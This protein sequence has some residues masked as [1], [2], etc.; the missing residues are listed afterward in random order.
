LFLV[1]RSASVFFLVLFC[2]FLKWNK[3]SRNSCQVGEGMKRRRYERDINI[4]YGEL[5]NPMR[6]VIGSNQAKLD[7]C[8]IPFS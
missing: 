7:Q 6:M 4:I 2:P 5:Y 1:K 3:Y 8:A